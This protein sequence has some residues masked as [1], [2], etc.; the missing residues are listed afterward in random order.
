MTFERFYSIVRPH[1]AASF[2]TVKRAKITIACIV[3]FSFIFRFPHLFATYFRGRYCIPYAKI[4]DKISGQFYY[5][6]T[7]ALNFIIPFVSL[8]IMN[9]FIIRTLYKRSKSNLTE[10]IGT[11]NENQGQDQGQS[12]GHTNQMKAVEKQI[13][14]MLLLVTYGYL[15]LTT[16]GYAM[17]LYV[18]YVDYLQSPFHFAAYV[19]FFQVGEKTYNTNFGINFFLYVLSGQ[20]FRKDLVNLFC[21]EDKKSCEI[22]RGDL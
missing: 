17:L 20:K 3:I 13:Y 8:V 12:Q 22:Y 7:F 9:S 18:N 1:K 2:N 6:L 10:A 4:L 5:W 19:L 14:T 15:I 21:S 11:R 16:P